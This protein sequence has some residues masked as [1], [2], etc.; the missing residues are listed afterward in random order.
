MIP[1]KRRADLVAHGG[2]E[3]GFG[4]ARLFGALGV[5]AQL[6]RHLLQAL[7]LFAQLPLDRLAPAD[8]LGQRN[9]AVAQ[10][11]VTIATSLHSLE[12]TMYAYLYWFRLL[13]RSI[14]FISTEYNNY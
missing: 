4:V 1:F 14:Y 13:I 9:I 6:V 11:V 10:F 8:L 5:D 2:E 7:P 3:V 12:Y